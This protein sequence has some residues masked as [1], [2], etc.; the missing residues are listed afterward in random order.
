MILSVTKLRPG[1][2]TMTLASTIFIATAIRRRQRARRRGCTR[3]RARRGTRPRLRS[4]EHT[5]ELQSL[6]HLVCRPP[7]SSSFPYTTLFRSVQRR[8]AEAV[9]PVLGDDL[10]RDEIT[11]R[12]ADDDSRVDDLHRDSHPPSTAS[13]APWMYAAAGEARNTTAP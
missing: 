1:E 4:E 10:E 3:R 8:V 13:T 9:G 5:S 6:R 7:L 11:A 2:Q 12:R